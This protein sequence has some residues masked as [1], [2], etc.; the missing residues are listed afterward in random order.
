VYVWGPRGSLS[1]D[2]TAARIAGGETSLT[3]AAAFSLLRTPVWGLDWS[4]S[5]TWWDF[6]SAS[7]LYGTAGVAREFG[8]VVGRASYQVYRAS[9][10]VVRSVSHTGDLTLS[11]PLARSAY[12]TV[13]ARLQRG[14]DLWTN[15][16]FVGLWTAF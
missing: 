5:A 8:R 4:A 11:V 16:L 9:T 15:G 10:A 6:Q 14:D 7:A 3:Y 1:A 13:Q 12:A 2:V